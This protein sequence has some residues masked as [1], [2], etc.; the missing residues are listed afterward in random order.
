MSLCPQAAGSLGT[1]RCHRRGPRWGCPWWPCARWPEEGWGS[2]QARDRLGP[3]KP[4]VP[5]RWQGGRHRLWR[6]SPSPCA[7]CGAGDAGGAGCAMPSTSVLSACKPPLPSSGGALSQGHA[8]GH[9]APAR[10]CPTALRPQGRS[11]GLQ[12]SLPLSGPRCPRLPCRVPKRVTPRRRRGRR[13]RRCARRSGDAR[14][15]RP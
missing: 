3:E 6:L 7:S 1:A 11:H 9:H 15:V 4:S 12:L 13:S 5:L 2:P 8:G 14:V 10:W